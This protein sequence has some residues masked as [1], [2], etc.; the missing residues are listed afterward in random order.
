MIRLGLSNAEKQAQIDTYLS[1][2]GDI[3][4]IIIFQPEQFALPGDYE[5]YSW[6]DIIM[7]KYFYPLLEKIDGTYL[8]IVNELLRNSNRS[9]LTYNCLHHYLNQTPHRLIFQYFPIIDAPEDILILADND[10]PG[11][12]KGRGF[13]PDMLRDLDI[14]GYDR[15]PAVQIDTVPV[16]DGALEA[17]CKE[18]DK[19]FD[20]LGSAD[21]DTIPR[22]LHIWC[23]R[24]KRPFLQPEKRYLARNQRFKLPNVATYKDA[25]DAGRISIDIPHRR[26]DLN[27]Y[28]YVS[29]AERIVF[30]STPFKVDL[31][32]AGEL[33]RWHEMA[34]DIFAQ[35]GIRR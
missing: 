16:P 32:Y 23:G 10:H 29:G 2:H 30:L 34:G 33:Q 8:L 31:Y 26:I 24:Y 27:D 19:L 35:A 15:R 3:R 6:A 1:Q 7:Y 25:R 5:T 12:Y 9:D 18:R 22:N 20:N 14:D 11:K 21:P 4:H 17:Y 13:T 28:L